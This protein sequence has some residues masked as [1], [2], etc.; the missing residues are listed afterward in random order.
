TPLPF[1][2][3]VQLGHTLYVSGQVGVMPGTVNLAP[4]G[5]VP[6]ARR[7]LENIKAILERHGTSL[8][9]VMKCTV[10]LADIK[11]WPAFNEVYRE[12]FKRNLPARSAL[13]AN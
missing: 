3:A 12:F 2:Q 4:G 8:D 5:L 6:E 7:V 13:G 10:F 9:H 11:D 1:S